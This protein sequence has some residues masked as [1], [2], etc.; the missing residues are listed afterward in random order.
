MPF[1]EACSRISIA[2]QC[3]RTLDNES[4]II[5]NA[6]SHA[7]DSSLIRHLCSSRNMCAAWSN[8]EHISLPGLPTWVLAWHMS[9]H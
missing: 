7:R 6:V 8:H 1:L 5:F 3:L 9:P 4:C 2:I